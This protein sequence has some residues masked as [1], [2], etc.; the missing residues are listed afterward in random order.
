MC[1][2]VVIINCLGYPFNGHGVELLSVRNTS[3]LLDNGPKKKDYV[4]NSIIVLILYHVLSLSNLQ[5]VIA[6]TELC[7]CRV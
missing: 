4:G 6:F 5:Y 7:V 3:I 1:Y 2:L